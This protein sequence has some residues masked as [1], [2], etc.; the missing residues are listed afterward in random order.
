MEASKLD[1]LNMGGHGMVLNDCMG[2]VGPLLLNQLLQFLQQGV[3]VQFKKAKK[4]K[5]KCL[6]RASVNFK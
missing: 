4:V 5:I 6:C 2:F 3:M 1:P